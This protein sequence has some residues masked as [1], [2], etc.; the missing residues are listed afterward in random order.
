MEKKVLFDENFI[1]LEEMYLDPY[2]PAFLVDKIKE[3]IL[4]FVEKIE[5]GEKNPDFVQKELDEMTLKI[6]DLEDEFYDNNSEIETLARESIALSIG[7]IL[8][9]YAIRIDIEDAL[10]VRTW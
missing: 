6:N 10:R 2:F 5:S 3:I 9:H 1:L 7:H 8:S 4:E